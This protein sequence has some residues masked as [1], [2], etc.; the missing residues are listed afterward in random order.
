MAKP[1]K[2]L[3]EEE[4][5]DLAELI[6]EARDSADYPVDQG[7]IDWIAVL[8]SD[9]FTMRYRKKSRS[10]TPDVITRRVFLEMCGNPVRPGLDFLDRGLDLGLVHGH[11]PPK[12]TAPRV[13]TDHRHPEED[14]G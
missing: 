9:R 7:T 2:V 4:W 10:D 14:E 6:N 12:V 13:P 8:L 3:T 5:L 1:K 11:Q